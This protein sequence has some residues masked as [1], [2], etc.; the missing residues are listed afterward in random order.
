MFNDTLIAS[1]DAAV[2]GACAN[3]TITYTPDGGSPSDIVALFQ[4]EYLP[5]Q[6]GEVMI[7]SQEKS[8]S[9]L[10]VDVPVV[11]NKDLV[12]VTRDAVTSNYRVKEIIKDEGQIRLLSLTKIS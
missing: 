8:V 7:A 6:T 5:L 11:T 4:N 9:V 10:K 2:L 12:S 1:L 3:E